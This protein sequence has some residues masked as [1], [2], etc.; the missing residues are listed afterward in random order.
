MAP[1]PCARKA[2]QQDWQRQQVTGKPRPTM[3]PDIATRVAAAIKEWRAALLDWQGLD[4]SPDVRR[5]I[6]GQFG[7]LALA[8]HDV[9]RG[10]R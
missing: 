4:R 5:E 9:I 3:P 2:R 10:T 8:E 7:R 6:L 1:C